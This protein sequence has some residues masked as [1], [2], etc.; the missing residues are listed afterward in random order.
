[1]ATVSDIERNKEAFINFILFEKGLAQNTASAYK[2]DIALFTVYLKDGKLQKITEETLIDFIF[3]LKSKNY[4]SLSIARIIVSIK[5]IFKF[6][7]KEKAITAN[8]FEDMES[9]KTRKKIP[10]A[11]AEVEIEKLLAQPDLS[12]REGLRDRAI[13]ELLYSSGVRVSELTGMELTDINLD[14][15][16]VRC[17]GKGSK[18]RIVPLGDYVIDA[19]KNYLNAR[20][21]FLKKEFTP[22]L[23]LT[24]LGRKFTRTGIWSMLKVYAKKAGIVKNVYPHIFRHSFATHLLAGGADLRSVQEMLGHADI[25]TTQI[26]THV[27][28]SRLKKIHKLF[29]PRG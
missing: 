17:F 12:S 18:E 27:D 3:S 2:S 10:E 7:L 8:P 11:L 6:M 15:K 19:L 4:S 9:F 20:N 5:S 28:R 1:M 25:S 13:M 24:R 22:S 23:F 29:H 26:Y 21:G 14:D 16:M